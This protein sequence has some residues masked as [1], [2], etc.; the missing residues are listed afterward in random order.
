[1]F[2][3]IFID[4][5]KVA[6]FYLF[7]SEQNCNVSWGIFG[8]RSLVY[9]KGRAYNIFEQHT[10]DFLW[11]QTPAWEPRNGF[12]PF[13]EFL[14]KN[15]VIRAHVKICQIWLFARTVRGQDKHDIPSLR[16]QRHLFLFLS[17][18]SADKSTYVRF[19]RGQPR[20]IR[21]HPAFSTFHTDASSPNGPWR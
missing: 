9:S 16:G 13:F 7:L 1:M 2:F 8:L 15:Q 19:P 18:T 4:W 6:A 11:L 21:G 10:T 5:N 20:T 14:T 12:I 17:F 3:S